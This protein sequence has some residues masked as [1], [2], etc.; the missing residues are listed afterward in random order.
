MQQLRHFIDFQLIDVR[1]DTVYVGKLLF[2]HQQTVYE[3]LVKHWESAELLLFPRCH[4]LTLGHFQH[5]CQSFIDN[6]Q[7]Y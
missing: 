4:I 1:L 7:K 2:S 6:S 3:R 5:S